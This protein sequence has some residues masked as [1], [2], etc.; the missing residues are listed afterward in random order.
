MISNILFSLLGKKLGK[1]FDPI[2]FCNTWSNLAEHG[3]ICVLN[4]GQIELYHEA[5]R[6]TRKKYDFRVEDLITEDLKPDAIAVVDCDYLF[7]KE[8]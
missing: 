5:E 6:I 4:D 8:V 1:I 2:D 3:S 7:A